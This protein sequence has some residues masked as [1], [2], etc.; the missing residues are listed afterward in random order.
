MINSILLFFKENEWLISILITIVGL[1]IT[2]RNIK[3]NFKNEIVKTKQEVSIS[4]MQSI[5]YDL[6]TLMGEM[7]EET[8]KGSEKYSKKNFQA[9][10]SIMAKILCYGS[11]DAINIA[12]HT[13]RN[14]YKTFP[15]SI[16][17]TVLILYS[18]LI[19]QIKFD[20]TGIVISPESYF[21]IKISD[22]ET[23]MKNDVRN[24][25]NRLVGL[26]NLNKDFLVKG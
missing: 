22:Y 1:L 13:Q 15:E 16:Q 12:T 5:P 7:S 14:A 20:L 25:I 10:K 24:E 8:K 11:C 21:K 6:F 18:L 19:V 17:W 3:R 23:K 2:S 9:Y 26:L 4:E